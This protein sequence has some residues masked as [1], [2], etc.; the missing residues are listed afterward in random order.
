LIVCVRDTGIGIS[1]DMQEAIFEIFTQVEHPLKAGGRGLGIGLTLVRS[2]VA[3]H[4]G[5]IEVHSAGIGQGSEFQV[6]APIV[7]A[8]LDDP[9][10]AS[11]TT[12]DSMQ[13]ARRV[14]VA[15]DN[16]AAAHM[17][18]LLLER[19]GNEVRT[20]MDGEKAIELAAEFLPDLVLMDLGMPKLDGLDAARRIRSEPWGKS[21]LLAA[22]TGF[23]QPSDKQRTKEAGFD[24]HLVKPI[25]VDDLRRLLAE[26]QAKKP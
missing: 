12:T 11:A 25:N 3:M 2:L 9:M 1:A 19:F 23:G 15:D 4:G 17:L 6:R 22:L 5:A 26:S 24:F 13:T 18:A 14:L 7:V 21:M 20:A 10:S 8:R 16:E